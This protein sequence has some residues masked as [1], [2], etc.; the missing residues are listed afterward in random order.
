MPIYTFAERFSK[1]FNDNNLNQTSASNMTGVSQPVISNLVNKKIDKKYSDFDNLF[2]I[3][4][5]D[6][7]KFYLATGKHLSQESTQHTPDYQTEMLQLIRDM[8]DEMR[9]MKE[10]IRRLREE[11]SCAQ[12]QLPQ[13]VP[14]HH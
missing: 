8:R 6:D 10:E 13:K 7:Q 12:V 11:K 2:K 1:I 9:E 4:K 5:N 3:C 14:E